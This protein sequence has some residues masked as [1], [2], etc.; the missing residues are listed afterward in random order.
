MALQQGPAW[1]EGSF[2][3][4]TKKSAFVRDA[5]GLPQP[6]GGASVGRG[7]E[8]LGC[9]W[10][11]R[12]G[13]V[14][15]TRNGVLLGVATT[16]LPRS[17]DA[18]E[19]FAAVGFRQ[20]GTKAKINFGQEPF[21]YVIPESGE[22]EADQ[23]ERKE[24]AAKL[25]KALAA[26]EDE[27]K[28]R[29]LVEKVAAEAQRKEQS[30]MI[31]SMCGA[32]ID[33]DE[34][35]ALK[36]LELHNG[37]AN[38]VVS[39]LLDNPNASFELSR[40]IQEDEAAEARVAPAVPRAEAPK[41]E[42]V[43]QVPVPAVKKDETGKTEAK[44]VAIKLPAHEE[45]KELHYD[46]ERSST[47]VLGTPF[48][49]QDTGAEATGPDPQEQEWLMEIEEQLRSRGLDPHV[50]STVMAQLRLGGAD[51]DNAV[52]MLP[53]VLPTVPV[54][55]RAEAG[56][57][58]STQNKLQFDKVSVG[59]RVRLHAPDT[60]KATA[61][62]ST[63]SAWLPAM[64]PAHG[65]V[66]VVIETDAS[67]KLVC[68]RIDFEET[69]LVT[70]WWMSCD[71][72]RKVSSEWSDACID[73]DTMEA[74]Q[75][76][77][78]LSKVQ[79]LASTYARD[80]LLLV[81]SASP[82]LAFGSEIP[83]GGILA[84]G[85]LTRV[86]D[87]LR[88]I[89][90]VS[91][92]PA[93]L[94]QVEVNPAGV[95]LLDRALV[96]QDTL[97]EDLLR[98]S[99]VFIR[100]HAFAIDTRNA[101]AAWLEEDQAL[102]LKA[103]DA[104]ALILDFSES[105][106]MSKPEHAI[107]IFADASKTQILG[108]YVG[109]GVGKSTRLQPLLVRQDHAWLVVARDAPKNVRIKLSVCPVPTDLSL[110]CWLFHHTIA[111]AESSSPGGPWLKRV[112]ASLDTIVELLKVDSLAI[113][114]RTMLFDALNRGLQTS[115]RLNYSKDPPKALK[116]LIPDLHS[117]LV[118]LNA[119]LTG[120]KFA[121][122]TY[123]QQLAALLSS[124]RRVFGSSANATSLDPSL[125]PKTPLKMLAPRRKRSKPE[126]PPSPPLSPVAAVVPPPAAVVP[127]FAGPSERE[128]QVRQL[129]QMGFSEDSAHEMLEATGGSLQLAMDQ[130]RLYHAHPYFTKLILIILCSLSADDGCRGW[131]R[132][133]G[134][135]GRRVRNGRYGWYG[136]H[137]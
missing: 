134:W 20:A 48:E 42:V 28:Q 56:S 70:H 81:L 53:D 10:N 18:K 90:A 110:A 17:N 92:P 66:A 126:S 45:V 86:Q 51:R 73:L 60:A 80:A 15:F 49:H 95:V 128:L 132:R 111:K 74:L 57:S 117:E 129:V 9:G 23:T 102:E 19:M 39:W 34:R 13:S 36:A 30:D 89:A 64:A 41:P 78:V 104:Q 83:D 8:V 137:G 75:G 54:M 101:N 50:T 99:A 7:R 29:K 68:V 121:C 24:R 43:A 38:A 3:Y 108:R 40:V 4:D 88:L 87:M 93:F 12:D 52:M 107:E 114:L 123:L 106:R 133:Y 79:H 100:K 130:V 37:D 71:A 46:W 67:T 55:Q 32:V 58:A 113:C 105:T 116:E 63:P 65:A 2:R 135:G 16:Q 131:G 98:A 77:E 1:C 11:L 62:A 26:Q 120:G 94:G 14:Y 82:A 6:Y 44:K 125:D 76:D 27:V 35:K 69:S 91:I 25:E 22:S 21:R 115:G 97:V 72:L 136:R 5:A 109:G 119:S 33:H 118:A 103:T 47:L 84:N 31:L 112:W 124:Y 96:G 61:S 85:A 127:P 122:P 59:M